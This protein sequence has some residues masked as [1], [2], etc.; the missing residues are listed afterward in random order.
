MNSQTVEQW[1]FSSQSI[2]YVTLIIIYFHYFNK[3][4]SGSNYP[5]EDL[6]NFANRSTAVEYR[7][8]LFPPWW[9]TWR[10]SSSHHAFSHLFLQLSGS[11]SWDVRSTRSH[12][13]S[14]PASPLLLVRCKMSG[15]SFFRPWPAAS[16][17][18]WQLP[19]RSVTQRWWLPRC[20]RSR[21]PRCVLERLLLS[22][23]SASLLR[24]AFFF[25]I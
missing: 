17:R 4:I 1:F 3:L 11:R 8:Q 25:K 9:H 12:S 15:A 24:S 2:G 16:S 21:C 14:P 18:C 20:S 23:V 10:S 6:F 5:I 7:C 13:R 19:A 22:S